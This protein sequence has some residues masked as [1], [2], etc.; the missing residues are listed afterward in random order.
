VVVAAKLLH[1]GRPDLEEIKLILQKGAAR[2]SDGAKYFE[3]MLKVLA[4]NGFIMSEVLP[5][6]R[7]LFNRQRLTDCRRAIMNAEG[8]PSFWERHWLRSF[9]PELEYRLICTSNGTC[10]VMGGNVTS[11]GPFLG[12]TTSIQR[13]IFVFPVV[14]MLNLPGSSFI[15]AS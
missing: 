4:K 12:Q 13:R 3:L 1:G 7:D 9:L 5:I 8:P 6:F 15:S 14:L 11:F 2:E 10:K